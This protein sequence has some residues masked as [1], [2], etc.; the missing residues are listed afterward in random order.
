[1][2]QVAYAYE[3][4]I[5]SPYPPAPVGMV[6]VPASDLGARRRAAELAH[7]LPV[8]HYTDE[9]Q[10]PLTTRYFAYET[11]FGRSVSA[12]AL[13]EGGGMLGATNASF[14]APTAAQIAATPPGDALANA[15]VALVTQFQA[16]GVPSEHVSS[17]IVV[18]FQNAWNADPLGQVNGAN[19]QLGVD[20]GYG[21]NVH[22][23]IA[24]I[25]GGTAPA[26]N[27]APAPSGGGGVTPTTTEE[28]TPATDAT[29]GAWVVDA[30]TPQVTAIAQ[31]I[32]FHDTPVV[33]VDQGDYSTTI[34]GVDYL[35][36]MWWESGMKS[37]AAYKCTQGS[38]AGPASNNASVASG[39]SSTAAAVI[40]GTLVV[41]ALVATGFA[42]RKPLQR[43]YHHH[44]AHPAHHR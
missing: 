24:S 14:I 17:P 9:R 41:G 11:P 13:F 12:L 30:T 31:N 40:L 4:S 44:T 25:A 42:A 32:A 28:P 23:A 16:S 34:G 5:E 21:P 15:A 7:V 38:G 33:W 19:G 18:A 27:T 36:V 43:A 2:N 20:G 22:D 29:C 10:G 37:V 35:F 8:Y 3:G 26:V 1:M 39:G 6:E